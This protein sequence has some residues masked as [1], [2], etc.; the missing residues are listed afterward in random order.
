MNQVQEKRSSNN[1]LV[2]LETHDGYIIEM[3]YSFKSKCLC[4]S[5]QIGCTTGC[6]FCAS[7]SKGFVRNLSSEEMFEEYQFFIERGYEIEILHFGG[8]GEPL[9]NLDNILEFKK[10]IYVKTTQLTTSMPNEESFRRICKGN[11][12]IL[13]VSLHSTNDKTRKYL[14]PNSMSL[15]EIIALLVE[16][17]ADQPY[18]KNIIRISYLL[19][20]NMNTS[21]K[22]QD[23]FIALAEQLD[24]CLLLLG[25]NKV[26]DKDIFITD[27]Q[28]YLRLL[29]KIRKNSI[30]YEDCVCSLSR[31]DIIGGCGTLYVSSK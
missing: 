1:I 27:M 7:G 26:N 11:F 4:I 12:D 17:T 29:K 21:E 24:L 28:N 6:R 22:E 31:R 5:T 13:I 23:E 16:I 25:Y 8:V 30:R 15:P 2:G 18:L 9:R 20:G 3:V 10:Q 19:L 14:I